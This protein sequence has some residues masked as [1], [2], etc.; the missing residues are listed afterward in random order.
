MDKPRAI[1]WERWWKFGTKA[2]R[3]LRKRSTI[4]SD[5]LRVPGGPLCKEKKLIKR[6]DPL[7]LCVEA[8][9]T[10][11]LKH[12]TMIMIK[13]YGDM[14]IWWP[15]VAHYLQ[16]NSSFLMNV[17][18]WLLYKWGKWNRNDEE[19]RNDK[20]GGKKSRGGRNDNRK[21]TDGCRAKVKNW[22]EEKEKGAVKRLK[23]MVTRGTI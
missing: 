9:N 23:S 14:H 11:W 15:T 2:S 22:K 20:M 7:C 8:N 16:R 5:K 13:E 12:Y 3:K 4:H 17:D 6:S 21:S 18:S 19:Q 10:A 1:Q